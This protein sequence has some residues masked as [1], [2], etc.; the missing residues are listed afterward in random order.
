[1]GALAAVVLLAAL[2]G[3]GTALQ[4][5]DGQDSASGIIDREPAGSIED[6]GSA[7][8]APTELETGQDG[9]I[10]N[11]DGQSDGKSSP[12]AARASG[13]GGEEAGAIAADEGLVDPEVAPPIAPETPEVAGADRDLVRRATID[14]TAK[15]PDTVAAKARSL[16][17][18]LGGRV[19]QEQTSFSGSSSV[20]LTL[21]VPPKNFDQALE[22]LS[23]LGKVT[24]RTVSTDDVTGQVTDLEGRITT[25]KASILRLQGFLGDA[26]DAAQI[27]MLESELLRRETELE[28]IQGQLRTLDAQ[29]AESVVTLTVSEPGTQVTPEPDDDDSVGFMDGLTRGWEAFTAVVNAIVV[30]VAAIAPFLALGLVIFLVVRLLRRTRRQASDQAPA[31]SEVGSPGAAPAP[32]SHPR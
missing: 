28:G 30:A 15:D 26:S 22:E 13:A 18:G 9:A 31:P 5:A 12:E 24:N 10:G 23:D 11:S 16:V 27:G 4:S 3:L 29:V 7:T 1:M 6:P 19:S 14:L 17:G 8:A 20:V 2:V 25:L 32:E 21:A